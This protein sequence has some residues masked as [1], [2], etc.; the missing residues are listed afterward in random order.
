MT[1]AAALLPNATMTNDSLC[2]YTFENTV[3]DPFLFMCK[4]DI[5]QP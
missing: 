2:Q 1:I 5:N 3:D 4:A